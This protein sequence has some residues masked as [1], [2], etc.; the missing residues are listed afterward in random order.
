MMLVFH[1]FLKAYHCDGSV[2]DASQAKTSGGLDCLMQM[3]NKHDGTITFGEFQTFV[4]RVMLGAFHHFQQAEDGLLTIQ[5]I[6]SIA[7]VFTMDTA[8]LEVGFSLCEVTHSSLPYSVSLGAVNLSTAPNLK[9]SLSQS[10]T[11]PPQNTC[12][13]KQHLV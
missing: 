7:E 1:Q 8:A 11:W 12:G 3:M 6:L 4:E 10:T 9:S 13:H 2:L 5:D